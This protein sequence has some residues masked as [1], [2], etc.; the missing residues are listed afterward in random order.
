MENLI[1][2]CKKPLNGQNLAQNS[3]NNP[4]IAS[5]IKSN[6]IFTKFCFLDCF[7]EANM[8]I[9]Y[10]LS[11]IQIFWSFIGPF[12]LH[13]GGVFL[14]MHQILRHHPRAM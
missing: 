8:N 2:V 13:V 4:K 6:P 12:T 5:K 1:L 11:K 14:H 10:F 3:P 9:H 7:N